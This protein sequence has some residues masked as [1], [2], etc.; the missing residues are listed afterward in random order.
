VN[1]I[2]GPLF[3]WAPGLGSRQP[4]IGKGEGFFFRGVFFSLLFLLVTCLFSLFLWNGGVRL[5][6]DY[7]HRKD[8]RC[9][10][11]LGNLKTK[12]T[13]LASWVENGK[14]AMVIKESVWKH[15]EIYIVKLSA[16]DIIALG[17]RKVREAAG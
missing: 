15:K 4:A 6:I 5:T 12:A 10:V 2:R 16:D 17:L 3:L 13:I 9:A 11:G 7:D 1:K 8:R 14:L